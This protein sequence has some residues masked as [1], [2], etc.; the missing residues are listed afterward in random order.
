[1]AQM[2][3]W[4]KA[5]KDAQRTQRGSDDVTLILQ[6]FRGVPIGRGEQRTA[7]DYVYDNWSR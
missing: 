4:E 1:M 6:M 3:K 2:T 7:R 5:I